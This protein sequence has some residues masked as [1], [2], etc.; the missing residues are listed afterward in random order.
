VGDS[1]FVTDVK[2]GSDAARQG[3]ARGDRVLRVG[4]FE[5]A[6]PGFWQIPY[7]FHL[8]NPQGTVPFVVRSVDGAERH[9]TVASKVIRGRPLL[10]ITGQN[11]DIWD[12]IRRA[13][14]EERELDFELVE[15]GRKAMIWRMPTF[16]A[17][18]HTIDRALGKANDFPALVLDLRGNGGGAEREL[19]RLLGAFTDHSDTV[20]MLYRRKTH[21]PL[22][23]TPHG[24]F[25]GKVVVLVDSRSASASE[26]FAHVIKMRHRGVVVGDR[27]WGGVMRGMAYSHQVG[28]DRVIFYTIEVSDAD[29]VMADSTHLEG[30][31]VIP[32]ELVL[33]TAEDLHERR[34]PA[35]ARALAIVGLDYSPQEAGRLFIKQH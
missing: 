13:E 15:I 14:N 31:G 7:W 9:I 16:D 27:T 3:L 33:P 28:V 24:N 8:I 34:D 25:S 12:L 10:D 22:I 20:G 18:D 2:A 21:V 4:P 23:V 32:D 5:P 35:L 26:I 29:I 30:N 6:R 1:C 17:D 11:D 19:L